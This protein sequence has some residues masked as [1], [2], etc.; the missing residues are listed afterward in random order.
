MCNGSGM[1]DCPERNRLAVEMTHPW[2]EAQV[3]IDLEQE[4]LAPVVRINGRYSE[5]W[6]NIA[7]VICHRKWRDMCC[8]N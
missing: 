7:D 4:G 5:S 3:W 8:Q 1:L 2:T 6:T